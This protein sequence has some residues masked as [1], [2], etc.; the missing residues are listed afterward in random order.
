VL[1]TNGTSTSSVAWT[2]DPMTR[3]QCTVLM[4][5]GMQSTK[6]CW[7]GMCKD[8]SPCTS[9]KDG[10]DGNMCGF[11]QGPTKGPWTVANNSCTGTCNWVEATQS[12]RC[13]DNPAQSC[14]PDSGTIVATGLAEVHDGFYV[15][16]LANLI[17]M[18][19][20][21]VDGLSAAVDQIGGFPG[22]FL[23]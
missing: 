21:N 12:G 16:Q 4:P 23:A 15:S 3:P 13:S 9:G 14:F 7:C 10:K 2:M 5:N 17:C 22:P 11:A 6:R 18:P 8:G 20:F 19:S 1:G